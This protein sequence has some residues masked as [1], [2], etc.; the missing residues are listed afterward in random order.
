MRSLGVVVGRFAH[1]DVPRVCS[2]TPPVRPS[3]RPMRPSSATATD[4]DPAVGA[5]I[6]QARSAA[7]LSQRQLAA[8]LDVQRRTVQNWE[9]GTSAIT[10]TN[11]RHL[12]RALD[13]SS[14]WIRFGD[15]DE[16]PERDDAQPTIAVSALTALLAGV[17][18]RALDGQ[19]TPR[20][21]RIDE[22]LASLELSRD[23]ARALIERELE[24]AL[25][26]SRTPPG[27]SSAA[28]RPQRRGGPGR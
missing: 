20:L 3:T 16:A 23:E 24:A 12:E 5:R 17:V 4:R 22:R 9:A 13:V 21:D 14:D 19:V 15:L 6:R 7:G 27:A 18:Q 8:T 1:I 11:L 28:P 2:T 10:W 25:S 26:R